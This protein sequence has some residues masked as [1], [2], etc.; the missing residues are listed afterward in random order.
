VNSS[1]PNTTGYQFSREFSLTEG[2]VRGT[3]GHL[4]SGGRD[5]R[6]FVVAIRPDVCLRFMVDLV[7]VA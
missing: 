5:Q 1:H 2:A 7:L 6:V 3:H 4:G